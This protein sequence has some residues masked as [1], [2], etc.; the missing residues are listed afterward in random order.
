MKKLLIIFSIISIFSS[1]TFSQNLSSSQPSVFDQNDQRGLKNQFQ[2]LEDRK[3]NL[4]ID[5]SSFSAYE[6]QLDKI[7]QIFDREKPHLL[8]S[9]RQQI[10]ARLIEEKEFA[11]IFSKL[12]AQKPTTDGMIFIGQAH[13][14][15]Y[16]DSDNWQQIIR[17]QKT[18]YVYLKY[19]HHGGLVGL[20]G[21]EGG[22]DAH[23]TYYLDKIANF[24]ADQGRISF[25]KQNNIDIPNPQ[26]V[27]NL[28]TIF[29][30][31]IHSI[32]L[33][34]KVYDKNH[35]RWDEIVVFSYFLNRFTNKE[36][37]M[38]LIGASGKLTNEG[39]VRFVGV[40]TKRSGI[41]SRSMD[42]RGKIDDFIRHSFPSPGPKE[43]A[44]LGR[45]RDII[46]ESSDTEEKQRFVSD[47]FKD[48]PNSELE[49]EISDVLDEIYTRRE[50]RLLELMQERGIRVVVF[51]AEH[52]ANLR[53]LAREK[54]PEI[55]FTTLDHSE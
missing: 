15:P 31:G 4:I 42:L 54:F 44:T 26:D 38:W 19:F 45:L 40:D 46:F 23:E 32:E 6:Q 14:S 12:L 50:N 27:Q 33:D 35:P 39:A 25:D 13:Y 48:H 10:H 9:E 47:F 17:S 20:E 52:Q 34:G 55:K 49:A 41:L 7:I 18:I 37:V 2:S 11:D 21:F 16:A 36:E 22:S 51:G 1:F 8:S 29:L 28:Q 24:L 53:R 43:Q 5:K 30:S 3:N